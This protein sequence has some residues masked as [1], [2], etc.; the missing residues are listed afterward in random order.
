MFAVTTIEYCFLGARDKKGTVET[1][2][3]WI[4]KLGLSGSPRSMSNSSFSEAPRLIYLGSQKGQ[5]QGDWLLDHVHKI[6]VQKLD[7]ELT[8]SE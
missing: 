6:L 1:K 3:A 4:P 8:N 5:L 2:D 7:A